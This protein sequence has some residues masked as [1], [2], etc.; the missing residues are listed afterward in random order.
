MKNLSDLLANLSRNA[1]D[2]D[3]AF[4]Q[5]ICLFCGAS[6]ASSEVYRRF[7]VCEGCRFHYALSAY[8]RLALL[9]DQGSFKEMKPHLTSLDPL[10]FAGKGSYLRRIFEAQKRTGLN[11]AVVVGACSINGRPA[12][13]AALDFGFLGGSM[14]CVVGEKVA[15]AFETAVQKGL[16]VVT[17]VASSGA[18]MQEGVLA[19]MQMAKTAAAVEKLRAAHLP[20]I[21]VMTNPTTGEVYTSFANLGD[22]I[23]AE[24]GAL[25][26]F[27]PLRVVQEA[28]GKPLPKGAHTAESHMAHGM[29]DQIVDRTDL[30]EM[31]SVL[32]HLLHQPSQ[33]AKKKRRGRVKRPAI[34]GFKRGP[35]WELVQ[36][37]RHRERPSATTY[38]SLLTESFVELHGDRFF[39]D[40]ASIV[41]GIGDID[42]QAVMLIGQER[43]RNGAQTYPEGFRKAQRLMKLA[44]NL[45]LPIV[46]LIDTPGAYPGLDAE[47]RGSGNVIASTLALASDLPVPMISVI[48]GEGGSEGALA[49]GVADRC[50]MLENA[51][52]SVMSPEGAASLL[53]RDAS[54]AEEIAQALKVTA[55]DCKEMKVIDEVVAEPKGGAHLDHVEAARLLKESLIR[56]LAELQAVAT[57]KLVKARYSKFRGMGEYDSRLKVALS[58]DMTMLEDY[59][60]R[61]VTEIGKRLPQRG[62]AGAE[63]AKGVPE[64]E[65]EPEISG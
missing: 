55:Y 10:S 25:M 3:V 52:Y 40:D 49:L 63:A 38:I 54:R 51:I 59:M 41:G 47:E 6:L 60:K 53:Y 36:L 64:P 30:R 62:K 24:P 21:S 42:E 35:A 43:S 19:L 46:T 34:K 28:T 50:L 16:P 26:G 2:D 23:I 14:G 17:V 18:R 37:A 12:V 65:D 27:A 56:E 4:E 1:K 11:E 32:I 9:V 20:F 29:I 15:L 45:G 31:I 33:Q 7:R 8:E 13:I 58:R 48:I 39:G 57:A 5:N 22:V 44:A 61:R